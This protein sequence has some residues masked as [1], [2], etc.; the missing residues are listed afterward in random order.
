MCILTSRTSLSALTEVLAKCSRLNRLLSQHLND[1]KEV[2]VKPHFTGTP[3]PDGSNCVL[4]RGLA[5][6]SML[7]H[8]L[9][10]S[11]PQLWPQYLQS[12]F[13]QILGM[14]RISSMSCVS[15]SVCPCEASY[16]FGTK[17]SCGRISSAQDQQGT[18]SLSSSQWEAEAFLPQWRRAHL[19]CLP[20]VET[21]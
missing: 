15:C 11:S 6:S 18:R 7:R 13:T 2:F 1:R 10:T 8:L 19:P 3:Q 9:P 12:L 17:D 20:N 4:W 5:L 14:E 21:A 16:Q